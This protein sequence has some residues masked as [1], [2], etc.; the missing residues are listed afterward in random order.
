[1]RVTKLTG[2]RLDL[3]ASSIR[4]VM[5]IVDFLPFFYLVGAISIWNSKIKQRIGD[6][7]ANTVVVSKFNVK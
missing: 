5:R 4:N 2:E 3:K 6:R 1:M 7:I